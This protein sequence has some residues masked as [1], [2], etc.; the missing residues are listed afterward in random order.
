MPFYTYI[1]A[2]FLWLWLGQS[3]LQAQDTR[4]IG[5]NDQQHF[6]HYA[7][8]LSPD[9]SL[10]L[11]SEAGNHANFGRSDLADIW[12]C[13]NVS[14]NQWSRP[15]NIGMPINS[16]QNDQCLAINLDENELYLLMEDEAGKKNG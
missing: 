6:P 11:Y 4:R 12:I 3:G 7:P 9:G 13:Q 1:L 5:V 14:E 16:D 2:L 8:V 10:L 15:V